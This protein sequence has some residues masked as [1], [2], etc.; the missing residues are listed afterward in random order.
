M[1]KVLVILT[2]FNRR[3]KTTKCI[4]SLV[5]GN[6]K[7][8]F[9]FVVV[10][11]NSN[12]GTVEALNELR[13]NITILSGDGNLYWA[14][15]MRKGIEYC[16]NN[17]YESDYVLFVNDDVDFYEGSIDKLINQENNLGSVVVGATS[18]EYGKL[19]YG[20]LKLNEGKVKGQYYPVQPAFKGNCDTFNMNCV[21]MPKRIF[22]RMGNFDKVYQHALADLDY[23]L[24]ISRS[25]YYIEVSED[26]VGICH[27]N[28]IKGTWKDTSL[29]RLDR[30]KKKES[31]KGP[32]F[33][34]WFYY[35]NKNFGLIFAIKYSLSPYIRILMGK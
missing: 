24:K 33:K 3:E 13:P 2:C 31:I 18:D 16:H 34:P 28:S 14:G 7:L 27:T 25:G 19:T 23:G 30:L 29:K 26:F 6:R 5:N 20:A 12:D 15:G 11:D 17:K 4:N 35:L 1:T 10:D 8:E 22:D 9:S 21:L 32:P